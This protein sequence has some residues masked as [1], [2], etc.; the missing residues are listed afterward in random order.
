MASTSRNI[1][2]DITLD[3]IMVHLKASDAR[4][5]R[6]ETTQKTTLT[7]I[8]ESLNTIKSDQEKLAEQGEKCRKEL[9]SLERK[10]SEMQLLQ[11][12]SNVRVNAMDTKLTL[13][14]NQVIY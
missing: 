4:N 5:E 2:K 6:F 9:A 8:N 14:K 10:Q 13:L 7:K 1:K 3:D 12:I 11:T